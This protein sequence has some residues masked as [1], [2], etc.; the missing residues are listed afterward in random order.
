MHEATDPTPIL[1]QEFHTRGFVVIPDALSPEWVAVLNQATDR[2]LERFPPETDAW[3]KQG[4][5]SMQALDVLPK[6][7]DFDFAI[8]NPITLGFARG[9]FGEDVTF[10]HLSILIRKPVPQPSEFKG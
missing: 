4:H 3:V 2:F 6:T 1:L 5:T 7:A 10:E 9:W 8:E